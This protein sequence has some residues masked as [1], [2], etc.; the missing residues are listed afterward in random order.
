MSDALSHVPDGYHTVT[1]Y[2]IVTDADALLSFIEKAF[3]GRTRTRHTDDDGRV[4][5]AEITIGNS[6]IMVGEANEEFPAN[7]S[8]IHLY[9]A[10]VDAMFGSA[11]AAG[12]TTVREPEDMPYGDRSGGVADLWGTQWWM[13]T[14]T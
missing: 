4:M 12:A 14:R 3:G 2:L 10:D 6:V 8:M 11:V 7:R 13:A 1:P 5:H 9:V